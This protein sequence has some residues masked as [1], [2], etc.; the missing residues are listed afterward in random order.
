MTDLAA[1][2]TTEPTT[3]STT[4]LTR[5]IRPALRN[6]HP[7]I[8]ATSAQSGE[9]PGRA[10]K[11]DM[12]ESPYGPSPKVARALATF[13]LTNRYPSITQD[14]LREAIGRYVGV[15]AR[16]IVPAAG[17]DDVL[18][19]LYT[20]FID[21][22]DEVIISDPTFGV[23]RHAVAIK[24]GRVVDVPLGR[25]PEFA[26]DPEA[27]LAAVTD[28]TRIIMICSPNNPTGNL[29]DDGAV[30]RI[31]REAPCVVAIDE[32]YAEFAGQSQLALM[33]RYAN[34]CVL[35]TMS[36]WAGLAG[37]RV[38]YGIFPEWMLTPIW[39]VVPAFCNI[40]TAA[41][42]AAIAAFED[43]DYLRDVVSTMNA[44]RD[45]LTARLNTMPG[46]SVF[47]S[48]T[49]F[50]LFQL[51]VDDAE[52]VFKALGARGIH[53]RYFGNPEHHMLDCLRVS[54]GTADENTLFADELERI[55]AGVAV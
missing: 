51:P 49:N 54:I 7:Y 48:M 37:M 10:V 13:H 36:K 17:M 53:V 28:R 27:I 16:R 21:D 41:E 12:N 18:T 46:V 55:L 6:A 8:P 50:L 45:A 32:A 11:L 42:T 25:R 52:P 29:L 22:G 1:R 44:D 14:H 31:A 35:R 33:D 19:N 20:A 9:Q 30:E 15:E 4:G 24:G 34:V 23:Y 5:L 2:P 47:P 40:S 26:L 3:Q 43:T 38:G 39:A